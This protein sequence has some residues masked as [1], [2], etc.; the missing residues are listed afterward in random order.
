MKKV[1]STVTAL[2]AAAAL[3]AGCKNKDALVDDDRGNGEGTSSQSMS[4]TMS[5]GSESDYDPVTSE[6]GDVDGDG[7]LEEMGTDINDIVDDVVTG[8]EDIVDDA[9]DVVDGR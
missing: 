3:L 2:L 7:F 5:T 9:L 1:F 6:T 8:A 4:D